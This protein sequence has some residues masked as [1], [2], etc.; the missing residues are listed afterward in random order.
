MKRTENFILSLILLLVVSSFGNRANAGDLLPPDCCKFFCDANLISLEAEAELY[1]S[2]RR[3]MSR[4]GSS[5]VK[6][7]ASP[8]K[9]LS[10][11]S[12]KLKWNFDY[13]PISATKPVPSA[14]KPLVVLGPNSQTNFSILKRIVANE[15]SSVLAVCLLPREQ[16]TKRI[17]GTFDRFIWL[18]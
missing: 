2:A 17:L 4:K 8:I 12:T 6:R 9:V 10:L 1:S 5:A 7:V 13:R 11:D 15:A 3:M 18:R 14:A 16:L